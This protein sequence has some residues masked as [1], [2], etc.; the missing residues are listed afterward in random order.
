MGIEIPPPKGGP[1]VFASPSPGSQSPAGVSPDEDHLGTP[2]LVDD[3]NDGGS[4]CTSEGE[5][6]GTREHA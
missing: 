3:L 1:A 6:A 5:P 4:M 2:E